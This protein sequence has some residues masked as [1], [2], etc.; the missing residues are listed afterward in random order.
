[1]HL[2]T[3]LS[4]IEIGV[5][6]TVVKKT[7]SISLHY[8]T[9]AEHVR[10]SK[11][12]HLW[13]TTWEMFPTGVFIV[14]GLTVTNKNGLTAQHTTDVDRESTVSSG[15]ISIY[16]KTTKTNEQLHGVCRREIENSSKNVST[17]Y[18]TIRIS[19]NNL[20]PKSIGIMSCWDGWFGLKMF[21]LS[22]QTIY[23]YIY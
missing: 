9:T 1:M 11:V 12:I 23:R 10:K 3:S 22:Q 7:T 4:T 21:G 20:P 8:S 2:R 5:R 18:C 15:R 19:H 17:M 13:S 16:F 14:T 6:C